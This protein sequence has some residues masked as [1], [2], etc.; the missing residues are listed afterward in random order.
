MAVSA[1]RWIPCTSQVRRQQQQ[2]EMDIQH[3]QGK[4]SMGRCT[5][6]A[7]QSS[8]SAEQRVCM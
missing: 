2:M 3:E 5:R 6:A 7:V 4:H 1:A 8:S